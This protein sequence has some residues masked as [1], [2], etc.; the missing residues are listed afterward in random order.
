M[1]KNFAMG[2]VRLEIVYYLSSFLLVW[3]LWKSKCDTKS[4]LWLIKP[5]VSYWN[6]WMFQSEFKLCESFEIRVAKTQR[7]SLFLKGKWE[8]SIIIDLKLLGFVKI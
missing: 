3:V 4:S 5:K 1:S 2:E 8:P 6:D 7:S